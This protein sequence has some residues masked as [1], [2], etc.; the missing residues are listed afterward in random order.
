M[1]ETICKTES[2]ERYKIGEDFRGNSVARNLDTGKR[3][4]RKQKYNRDSAEWT[5]KSTG[6]TIAVEDKDYRGRTTVNGKV[7]GIDFLGVYV[8]K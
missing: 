8:C 5:N 4:T 1:N 7:C 6:R 2:G 3:Y